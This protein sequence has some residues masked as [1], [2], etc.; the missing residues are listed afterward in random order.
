MK[1]RIA[2]SV[3]LVVTASLLI[4]GATFAVFSDSAVNQNNTFTAGTVDIAA[5]RD[6]GDPIPGP[7]FY[8]T[9]SEGLMPGQSMVLNPTGSWY[10]GKSATRTLVVENTGTL[11][12][13]LTKISA[14]LHNIADPAVAAEFANEL[15]LRIV[16]R[17]NSQQVFFEGY[18]RELLAGPVNML[19]NAPL[20]YPGGTVYMDF[21]ATLDLDAG[22]NLQGLVPKVDFYVHAEQL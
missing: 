2:I 6:L 20:L 14:N 3:M 8:T 9:A 16:N 1:K 19:V 18:L 10:P 15:Y 13:Q 17:N 12:A 11:N 21:M 7:M 22:N 5:K 4:G